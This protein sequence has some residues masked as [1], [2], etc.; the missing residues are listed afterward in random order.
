MASSGRGRPRCFPVPIGMA[1][2]WDTRW[3]TT[4][5]PRSAT[6]ARAVNNYWP[7]IDGTHGVQAN[8]AGRLTRTADGTSLDTTGCVYRSPVINISR[9]PLWGRI[10]EAFGEDPY[11]DL[12]HDGGLRQGHAGRRSQVP[13]AGDDAEA[14]RGQQPGNRAAQESSA[15]VSERMLMEYYLPHFKAG[16]M[17]GGATSIMSSYNAPQRR[18]STPRTRCC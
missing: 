13:E 9:H 2:T 8:R 17:E 14:L 10:D 1:S 11:P 7:T 12:T 4:S 6:K 16:I 3:S 5:R 18:R 15:T